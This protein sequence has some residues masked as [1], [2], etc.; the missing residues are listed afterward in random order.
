M[1]RRLASIIGI[2]ALS[3]PP[4]PATARANSIA[5]SI[6][7]SATGTVRIPGVP[8]TPPGQDHQCC[9]KACHAGCERKRKN[10]DND[11]EPD[12]A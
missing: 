1:N 2:I 9:G 4:I 12:E 3:L 6:C 10:A 7:G 5:L 8:D 11:G